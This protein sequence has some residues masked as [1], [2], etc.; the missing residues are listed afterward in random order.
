LGCHWADALAHDGHPS[1][2]YLGCIYLLQHPPHP[3]INLTVLADE[4]IMNIGS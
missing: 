4:A 3:V 2:G 1:R